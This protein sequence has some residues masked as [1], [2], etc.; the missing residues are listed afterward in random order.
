MSLMSSLLLP[1]LT[2]G[3]ASLL[4]IDIRGTETGVATNTVAMVTIKLSMIQ[5]S[6]I[7]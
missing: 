3:T 7:P 6:K 5:N 4:A 2:G 1:Y